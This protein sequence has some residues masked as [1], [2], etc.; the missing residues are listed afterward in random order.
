MNNLYAHAGVN[1][2]K[3]NEVVRRIK[4]SVKSTHTKAVL[5]GIGHFGGLYDIGKILKSY[6]HPI[7]VQSIDGVGTKLS[8][9][10]MAK[11]YDSVGEDIVGHSCG[12]IIAMGAR[13]LTFLDYV[14][15]E[16]LVPEEMEA[17]V[18]GMAKACKKAGVAIIG[19]ET[20]EMPGIYMKGEHDIAGCITGVVEKNKI[21]TGEKIKEG[22]I[23]FGFV[24]SGLHTNGFS[25]ARKLIF[26]IG[27]YKINS[28]IPE[29]KSTIGEV[30]LKVHTNYTNPVLEM[31]DNK[32][33]IRGIAHITGGGFIENIPRI[34]PKNLDAEITKGSWPMLPIFPFMQKIG[35]VG[36][37][38][39]YTAFNMGIG[40]VLIVPHSEKE[41]MQKILKKY[42]TFHIKKIGKIIKGKG[43]VILK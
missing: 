13:P 32:V 3:G 11:K 7:L 26:E 40:L 33:N 42:P 12:D 1:I 28:R 25:L 19:G 22:D 36:E 37:R 9:A 24:S 15:N 23:M 27:K 35:N 10:R 31:L 8:V 5:T 29:L 14:A 21:I 30:L 39:M 17:M 6:K 18:S 4:K 43:K 16:I 20:A 38:E 34:L 41:K 2:D